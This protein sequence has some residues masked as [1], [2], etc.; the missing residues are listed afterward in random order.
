MVRTHGRAPRG[1]RLVCAVPA[2]RW[3]TTTF[4]CGLRHD[5]L[6]APLVL[7]CA[8]NGTGFLACIQQMLALIL[9]PGALV[10]L[11]NLSSHKVAGVREAVEAQGASLPYLPPCSPDLNP[12]EQ[13]RSKL[14]RLLRTE[15]ARTMA[16]LWDAIGQLLNQFS[17][18]ERSR[19]LRHRGYAYPEL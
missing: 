12:I 8:V 13:A 18:A 14:K 4:L 3:H 5:G 1:E 16:A 19:H 2:G 7:D 10:V 11:D 17:P 9:A 6:V 15:A